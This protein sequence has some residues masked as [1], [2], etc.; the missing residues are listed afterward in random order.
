[1]GVSRDEESEE[2]GS[3]RDDKAVR[4]S[5]MLTGRLFLFHRNAA[6]NWSR[7]HCRRHFHQSRRP[8]HVGEK[9]GEHVGWNV[10]HHRK[11]IIIV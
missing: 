1:M 3:L 4:V 9:T 2:T 5:S 10:H 7:G 8:W 6:L 11:P